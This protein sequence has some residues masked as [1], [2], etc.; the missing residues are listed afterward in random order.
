MTTIE[1]P[2]VSANVD[3]SEEVVNVSRDEIDVLIR[4]ASAAFETLLTK[5]V[6]DGCPMEVIEELSSAMEQIVQSNDPREATRFLDIMCEAMEQA[7]RRMRRK[8]RLARPAVVR[9]RL[10]ET[11][12]ARRVK[13]NKAKNWDQL[14]RS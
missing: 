4:E 7:Q 2:Q 1:V 10:T 14:V 6:E 5:A 9:K 3:E 12:Q 11:R 13:G 8:R